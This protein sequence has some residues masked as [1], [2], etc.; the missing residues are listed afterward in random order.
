ME[1]PLT[2]DGHVACGPLNALPDQTHLHWLWL[3]LA[4]NP[5]HRGD[6]G[7]ANDDGMV[8]HDL[9]SIHDAILSRLRA[10]MKRFR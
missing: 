9:L 10:E 7:A 8:Q 2:T 5:P 4:S 1:S 6:A 3:S